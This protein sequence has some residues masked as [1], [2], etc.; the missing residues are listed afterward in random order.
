MSLNNS[1][2][3]RGQS[4]CAEDFTEVALEVFSGSGS[5][6]HYTGDGETAEYAY[7]AIHALKVTVKGQNVTQ[8]VVKNGYEAPA[9]RNV[10][11][12]A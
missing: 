3:I 9:E 10:I 7:G 12:K 5:F 4:E 6:T 8:T 1:E 11:I 2:Y